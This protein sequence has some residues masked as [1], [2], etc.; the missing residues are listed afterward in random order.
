MFVL[1]I[2]GFNLR[3]SEVG[4]PYTVVGLFCY[5]YF[6]S[7]YYYFGPFGFY[8]PAPAYKFYLQPPETIFFKKYSVRMI[9]LY[10]RAL[11]LE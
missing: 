7:K 4:N 9:T 3:R 1:R 8:I 11:D 10:E 5:R 2:L 6:F